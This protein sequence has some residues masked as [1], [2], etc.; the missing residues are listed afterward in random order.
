MI[1]WHIETRKLSKLK[2]HPKNPRSL[3]KQQEE[4]ITQSLQRFGLADKPIVNTD[5]TII[6]GHQR[7]R[8]LSKLG[9]KEIECWV[10]D[11]ELTEKEVDELNV[12]LNRNTGEFDYDIL[13][14][15]FEIPDLVDWGFTLED[16]HLTENDMDDAE[17][18]PKTKQQKVCPNCGHGL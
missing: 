3:N 5:G 9:Y 17:L 15:E 12:R 6:G 2:N 16:L 10:P 11:R 14:N 7:K 8:I 13:A 18:K 1:Q 4:Q